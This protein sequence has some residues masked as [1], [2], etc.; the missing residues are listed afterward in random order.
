MRK[1]PK[2]NDWD[3]EEE[4]GGETKAAKTVERLGL[5]IQQATNEYPYLSFNVIKGE[6]NEEGTAY[7]GKVEK[8]DL[9]K[10][11]TPEDIREEDKNL[12]Q[13]VRKLQS[14]E[15]TKFLNKN[16]PF[17]GIWDTILNAEDDSLPTETKELIQEYMHPKLEKLWRDI[18]EHPFNF[19]LPTNKP[20]T[21]ANLQ[22]AE[23]VFNPIQ[24]SFRVEKEADRYIIY[25]QVNLPE[26]KISLEEN[27][28]K[29]HYVFQYHH[30]YFTWKN[31]EDLKWVEQFM[32]TGFNEIELENW[33][34]Y[35][36]STLLPL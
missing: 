14:A 18:S 30:Q 1:I 32:P 26:G 3:I 7:V 9:P 19:H 23:L 28:A 35:L 25:A 24:P 36:Q 6:V 11:A 31:R 15:I 13:T 8:I 5:V 2:S 16:S 21:T 29:S 22:M 20:F 17:Q 4:A 34:D 33:P 12:V 10:Y 27:H